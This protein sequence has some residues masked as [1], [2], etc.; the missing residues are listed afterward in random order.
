MT[1]AVRDG[2]RYERIAR[3]VGG[4]LA[5][6]L[7]I[8]GAGAIVLL[9][10]DSPEGKLLQRI[11]ADAGIPLAEYADAAATLTAHPANKTALLVGAFMPR[12]D[13]LPLGDLYASQVAQLTDGW[14]GD[15][16]VEALAAEVGGID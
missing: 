3:V 9:D 13:L 4:V 10:E 16:V 2:G 14:T 12:T 15:R 8:T 7:R 11:A 6:A 1:E 5:E